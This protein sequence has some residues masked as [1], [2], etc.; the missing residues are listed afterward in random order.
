MSVAVWVEV[1][2]EESGRVT[3]MGEVVG[4]TSRRAERSVKDI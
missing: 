3:E 4:A 2:G 1:T